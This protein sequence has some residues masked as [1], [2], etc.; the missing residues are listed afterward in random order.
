[1]VAVTVGEKVHVPRC[2]DNARTHSGAFLRPADDNDHGAWWWEERNGTHAS[3]M[4]LWNR[5]EKKNKTGPD[6]IPRRFCPLPP[7]TATE[8]PS[9]S[10]WRTQRAC[11][12]PPRSILSAC[13][14]LRRP[15]PTQCRLIQWLAVSLSV[16]LCLTVSLSLARNIHSFSASYPVS[17][18]R[19]YDSALIVITLCACNDDAL[20]VVRSLPFFTLGKMYPIG[21]QRPPPPDRL[22]YGHQ[23]RKL[24]RITR[25]RLTF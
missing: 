1:M 25:N 24:S 21:W 11:I 19:P 4:T 6:S 3:A 20:R 16:S 2:S 5:K 22:V 14:L 12:S 9:S 23:C 13:F 17:P 8:R 15:P 18:R 7:A 10:F